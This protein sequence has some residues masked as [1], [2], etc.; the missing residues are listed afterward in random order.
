M[1]DALEIAA[2]ASPGQTVVL[3]VL[4]DVSDAEMQSMRMQMDAMTERTGIHFVAIAKDVEVAS[5]GDQLER[6]DKAV[7]TM[8]DWLWEPDKHNII[9]AILDGKR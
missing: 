1:T 4:E 2:V 8:S 7:R 6:L 3:R 9:D 5:V